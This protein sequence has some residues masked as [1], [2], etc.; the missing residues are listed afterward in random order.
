MALLPVCFSDWSQLQSFKHFFWF[1]NTIPGWEKWGIITGQVKLDYY[2][3]YYIAGLLLYEARSIPQI[4]FIYLS[5][6]IFGVWPLLCLTRWICLNFRSNVP[7]LFDTMS[8]HEHFYIYVCWHMQGIFTD[9]LL[10]NSSHK[11]VKST[12]LLSGVHN[13]SLRAC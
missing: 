6:F 13:D 3:A 5:S 9:R 2:V 12:S 11:E 10:T 8:C 1:L 4:I 7:V